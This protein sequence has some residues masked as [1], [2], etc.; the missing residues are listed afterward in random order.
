MSTP[1]GVVVT[2]TFAPYGT[3]PTQGFRIALAC[4]RA[5]GMPN[6]L[7][8]FRLEPVN[9]A[10]GVPPRGIFSHV[11]SPTDLEEFP[12]GAPYPN[13]SPPWFRLDTV[14]LVF[15]SRA[16]ADETMQGLLAEITALKGALDALDDLQGQAAVTIGTPASS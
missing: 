1:R 3:G 9:P 14:D 15:R 8:A 6:E 12:V 4:T 7:F 2:P 5:Q 16:T 13:A 10:A 11:C